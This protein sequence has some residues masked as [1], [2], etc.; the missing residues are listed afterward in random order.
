[1]NEPTYCKSCGAYI[2]EGKKKCLACGFPIEIPPL[3]DSE[4]ENLRG[5]SGGKPI[6]YIDEDNVAEGFKIYVDGY[7]LNEHGE[8]LSAPNEKFGTTTQYDHV[9][10]LAASLYDK[11]RQEQADIDLDALM[12]MRFFTVK[13]GGVVSKYY[14]GDFPKSMCIPQYETEFGRTIN[15]CIIRG[16]QVDPKRMIDLK[17]IER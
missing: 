3:T 16:G 1:M 9:L 15:G 7:E 13:V 12:D 17:L 8:I 2:P 4:F 14:F 6:I 10:N 11:A 5:H